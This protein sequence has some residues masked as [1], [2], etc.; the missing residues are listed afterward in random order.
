[1]H[2]VKAT[3]RYW[4]PLTAAVLCFFATSLGLPP[5]AA[6]VLIV[7]GVGFALDAGTTWLA[8]MG[9]GGGL[10]EYRQ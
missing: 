7:A 5:L 6:Y 1:V 2:A 4:L 8:R 3:R 10:H 9:S